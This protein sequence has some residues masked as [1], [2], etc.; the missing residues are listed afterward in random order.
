M[1]VFFCFCWGVGGGGW[2]WRFACY[3]VMTALATTG[4]KLLEK[5]Y[6]TCLSNL[7]FGKEQVQD[8]HPY[9]PPPGNVADG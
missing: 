5:I 4:T 7:N 6:K 1:D 2:Y 8:R 9:P 3:Y